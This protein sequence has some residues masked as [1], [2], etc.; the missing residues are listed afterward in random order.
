[1]IFIMIR[2]I[3]DEGFSVRPLHP[4]EDLVLDIG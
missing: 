2:V 1:M 4:I 3:D